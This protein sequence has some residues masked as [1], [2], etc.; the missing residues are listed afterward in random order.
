MCF[1]KK[2]S[3]STPAPTPAT[4]FQPMPADTSNTQQRQAAILSSTDNAQTPALGTDLGTGGA[5]P[6]STA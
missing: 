1:G 5:M 3:T 2:S 4:T 6:K